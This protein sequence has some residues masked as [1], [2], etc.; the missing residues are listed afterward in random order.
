[1]G[2]QDFVV[3][4]EIHRAIKEGHRADKFLLGMICTC[5]YAQSL[6]NIIHDT[7]NCQHLHKVPK[8]FE[9]I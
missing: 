6:R 5:I 8:C 4:K 7:Q 1:M 9:V 3:I 2:K